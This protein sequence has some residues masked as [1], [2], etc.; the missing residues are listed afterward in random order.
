RSLET[1]RDAIARANA[2]VLSGLQAAIA[3]D[4]VTL[5]S[6]PVASVDALFG[7]VNALSQKLDTLPMIAPD[8]VGASPMT[9]GL[10]EKAVTEGAAAERESALPADAAWYDR[11]WNEVRQWPAAA[12]SGLRSDLGGIVRVEKLSDPNQ[13][14][15]TV[16]QAMQ[17]RNNLKQNLH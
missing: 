7:Q 2:P 8:Q 1:A 4:I 16:D 15:L 9:R 12:W 14:L 13:V 3:S 5:K 11:A 10:Q 17:L 6:S